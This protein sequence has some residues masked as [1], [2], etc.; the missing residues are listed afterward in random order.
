MNYAFFLFFK[1][2]RS[3]VGLPDLLLKREDDCNILED[4]KEV[5]Q[6]HLFICNL[7]GKMLRLAS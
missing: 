6:T 1:T 5:G 7:F 2:E 4:C 3:D